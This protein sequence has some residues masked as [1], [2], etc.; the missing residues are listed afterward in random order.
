MISTR[1][2]SRDSVDALTQLA[3]G[4]GDE[5]AV[6]G[7]Q[8]GDAERHLLDMTLDPPDAHQRSDAHE[9][10]HAELALAQDEHP[11]QDVADDLLRAEPK[12]APTT[13]ASGTT[14]DDGRLSSISTQITAMNTI[15]K[16][17]AHRSAPISA[18]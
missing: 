2:Q 14:A 16:L 12:P 7:A 5:I 4:D 1:A 3:V 11:R 9:V 15:A 18:C 8:L 6:E 13:D 10:A 17:I